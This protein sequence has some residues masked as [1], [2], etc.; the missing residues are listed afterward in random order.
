MISLLLRTLFLGLASGAG[1][2]LLLMVLVGFWSGSASAT[3]LDPFAAESG[4]LFMQDVTSGERHQAPLLDTRVN[5]DITGI[6]A[7]VT[8]E[9][10]FSNTGDTWQEGIYAFPLPDDAAVDHMRLWIGERFIEGDIQER[11]EAKRQYDQAKAEGKQASLLQQE[12]PNI[13]TTSVANIPPGER[14]KIEIEYQHNV[15]Y[16]S[17]RYTLRFPMVVAPRYIPGE[18]LH[19]GEIV[20]SNAHAWAQDTD[21]VPDASRISPPVANED[22]RNKVELHIRLHTGLPLAYIDSPYHPVVI[23][24]ESTGEY[25][26]ELEE[27]SMLANRDFVLDWEFAA[28]HNTGAAWFTE[29]HEG[30]YYGLLMLAP[31]APQALKEPRPREIILVADTSGSMH[32]QSMSQAKAALKLAVSRLH[33]EDSFNLIV[34]NH[35]ASRLY[36][37]SVPASEE[38]QRTALRWIDGL[39]ADG[40]TEMFP[41]MEL[42]LNGVEQPDRLRQIIFV[43]DGDVGNEEALFS[44]IE[45]KLGNSRLFTVGIGS[46]PNS[47]FMSRAAEQGRGSFTYIGDVSEVQDKMRRLLLQLE[48]PTLTDIAVD[49]RQPVEQW[50]A[51]VPDLYAGEPVVVAVRSSQPIENVMVTGNNGAERW[52]QKL[53]TRTGFE[54]PGLHVL[55]AR[56][57]IHHLMGLL[58]GSAETAGIREKILKVAMTHHLVSRY[59]SLVAVDKTPVRPLDAELDMQSVP[60]EMPAGWSR[61]KVFGSLPQTATPAQLYLLLG[62]AGLFMAMLLLLRRRAQ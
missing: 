54:Y 56:R 5:M 53:S 37:A 19:E 44:L 1:T 9:Q 28:T 61:A 4:S 23:S 18:P 3:V 58:R 51:I 13:F 40:G 52:R 62:L 57:Q 12:R 15:Q 30:S 11:S 49:W 55:W 24:E 32:G 29:E 39:Q 7:R 50:P 2:A 17:G 41:A 36:A 16:N 47:Y 20:F 46:A 25:R 22:G 26:I 8:V 14:V 33:A 59:T 21:Q 38:N 6:V 60:V 31:P 27:S 35:V 42:A 34:F 43:T 45:Q 48:S 10:S